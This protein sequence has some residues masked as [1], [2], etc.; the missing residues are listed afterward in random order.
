MLLKDKNGLTEEEFL[1][2]YKPGDYERPSVTVDIAI[3][4]LD[5][6]CTTLKTLLIKRNNNTRLNFR[7]L[8]EIRE[9]E[10]VKSLF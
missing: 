9:R 1:R 4:G 6:D 3:L 8:I 2:Q 5:S 7:N 10:S